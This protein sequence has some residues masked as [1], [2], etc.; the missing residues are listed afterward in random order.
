MS[1]QLSF[2]CTRENLRTGLLF[3][4]FSTCHV[5][6]LIGL[7]LAL[8][9]L[10]APQALPHSLG[11]VASMHFQ[12][13]PSFTK[14]SGGLYLDKNTCSYDY[15]RSRC[16]SRFSICTRV[17]MRTSDS[18]ASVCTLRAIRRVP[19]TPQLLPHIPPHL[20]HV[21][22]QT[23]FVRTNDEKRFSTLL[24]LVNKAFLDSTTL[25]SYFTLSSY[26]KGH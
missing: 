12:M 22:N 8:R 18:D 7:P 15:Q 21:L 19:A 13:Q 11:T 2:S 26:Q 17:P 4:P 3:T 6:S 24:P 5:N 10:H 20:H 14:P 16:Y 25:F 1:R 23:Q 9:A